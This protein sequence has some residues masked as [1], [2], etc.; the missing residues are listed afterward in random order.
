M[1][2]EK[3]TKEEEKKLDQ[4]VTIEEDPD[5]SSM[6][7][8]DRYMRA[9]LKLVGT[10]TKPA[11]KIINKIHNSRYG[12]SV[13]GAVAGLS[14][15]G[16]YLL[17]DTPGER[18]L[19]KYMAIQLPFLIVD[20][21]KNKL[22]DRTEKKQNELSAIA[23]A[24]EPEYLDG[25][26]G[27]IK[28]ERN[29]KGSVSTTTIITDQQGTG[30]LQDGYIA[31]LI[32]NFDNGENAK[33]LYK[34]NKKGNSAVGEEISDILREKGIEFVPKRYKTD[35][36]T[37]LDPGMLIGRRHVWNGF[38]E[39]DRGIERF[40]RENESPK[41][42][43]FYEWLNAESLEEK[44]IKGEEP[45]VGEPVKKEQ[46]EDIFEKMFQVYSDDSLSKINSLTD[47][48]HTNL[49]KRI[50][51]AE[52]KKNN[53][54][55]NFIA[56]LNNNYKSLEG[57]TKTLIHGDLHQGNVMEGGNKTHVIDWDS[58]QIG[59]PYQ[60]FMYFSVISDFEKS[61]EYGSMKEE[62]L[63]KQAEII[64]DFKPEHQK[65][66]EFETYLTLLTRIYRNRKKYVDEH[67]GNMLNSA[68]YLLE[69]SKETLR[70]Y[71]QLIGNTE[72]EDSYEDYAKEKFNKKGARLD[73]IKYESKASIS[74]A[75]RIGHS[76]PKKIRGRK[77]DIGSLA[78]ENL[79]AHGMYTTMAIIEERKGRI[80]DLSSALGPI[81][82]GAGAL[83]MYLADSLETGNTIRE[84]I[85]TIS[86]NMEENKSVIDFI[87][88]GSSLLLGS[89]IYTLHRE[90]IVNTI[91]E[92]KERIFPQK[93]NYIA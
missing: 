81:A 21:I 83:C 85:S 13:F 16:N 31:Q 78:K 57:I 20:I 1:D 45:I 32:L 44:I 24:I 29:I 58:A 41:R 50:N 66:I 86:E 17:N 68:K 27:L 73:N 35:N 87:K 75:H 77:G 91:K 43:A 12:Y 10:V 67:K 74:Y 34:Y 2:L 37:P 40:K 26:I 59:I 14:A 61:R 60:D 54:V 9:C 15:T 79:E 39:R 42:G 25:I 62:F 70:E 64:P 90:K 18:M 7:G 23:K 72:L 33:L 49:I 52:A 93:D 88:Y 53:V 4:P 63:K 82:V 28:K 55:N 8:I 69:K 65:M 30:V 22:K 56:K 89:A 47:T 76:T 38:D 71:S 84:T 3:I 11:S 51:P 36:V 46:I 48:Q 19:S 6:K 80:R 5:Y 92:I